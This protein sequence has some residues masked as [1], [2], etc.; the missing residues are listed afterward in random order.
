MVECCI[1]LILAAFS[2]FSWFRISVW[3]RA[4]L[5]VVCTRSGRQSSWDVVIALRRCFPVLLI[6]LAY[7]FCSA[8]IATLIWG[9]DSPNFMEF[10]NTMVRLQTT[11]TTANF[12]D[13]MIPEYTESRWSFIYFF[14][15]VVVGNFFLLALVLGELRQAYTESVDSRF[16]EFSRIRQSELAKAFDALALGRDWIPKS[17]FCELQALSA[18]IAPFSR[19]SVWSLE[20]Q[21]IRTDVLF[22]EADRC[23]LQLWSKRV[24]Q[25]INTSVHKSYPKWRSLL[26]ARIASGI[27][28]GICVVCVV[29][30]GVT[31]WA[32][33]AKDQTIILVMFWIVQILLLLTLAE[34]LLKLVLF[35]TEY[36]SHFKGDALLLFLVFDHF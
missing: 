18:K 33:L 12:P 3:V 35:R 31:S 17:E 32:V 30:M 6:L 1:S 8:V 36:W 26:D 25:A 28:I 2:I 4:A 34:A 7:L 5:L 9:T 19:T 15:F 24:L 20:H 13:V 21:K 22:G 27:L 14:V 10:F 16:Q 11:L 23:N 29:V